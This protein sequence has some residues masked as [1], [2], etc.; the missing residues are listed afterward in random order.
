[1][2]RRV[3]LGLALAS[4]LPR[5]VSAQLAFVVGFV[6]MPLGF[7]DQRVCAEPPFLVPA[8]AN[9][10]AGTSGARVGSSQAPAI[11]SAVTL[12]VDSL[13]RHYD[14]RK[15]GHEALSRGS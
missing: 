7:C 1:G 3:V 5:G 8:E 14:V 2:S 4:S 15:G 12:E 9:S 11:D 10:L 13:H 6:E